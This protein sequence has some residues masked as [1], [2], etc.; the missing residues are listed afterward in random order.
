MKIL[1]IETSGKI[2]GVSILEDKN[3]L[4]SISLNNGLTHSETLMPLIKKLFDNLNFKLKDI[5]LIVCD[6]G[7]GSFTGIRIGIATAKAFSDALNIPA[8]GISSLETLCYNKKE[9]G[10]I[11]ALIDAKNANC[12]SAIF[13][14]IDG[15]YILRRDF[16]INNIDDLLKELQNLKL[17]YE[18]TFVGDGSKIYKEKILEYFPLSSF[19]FENI[20]SDN[21]ALAGLNTYTENNNLCEDLLPMYL[22]KSQAEI[23]MEVKE[24]NEFKN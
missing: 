5:D 16:D 7:P 13:E 6:K 18:L 23:M 3:I 17:Q 24:K 2:C 19:N 20:S 10:V 9:N 1:S 8:I 4:K 12:Y 14:N 15:K 21:L 22:R 11:C